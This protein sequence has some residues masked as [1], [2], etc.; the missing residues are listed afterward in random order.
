[1]ERRGQT[2]PLFAF[3]AASLVNMIFV[4]IFTLLDRSSVF[5]R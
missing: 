1:M 3:L 2:F 5:L 4:N